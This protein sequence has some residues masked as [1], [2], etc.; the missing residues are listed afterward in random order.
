MEET[1]TEEPKQNNNNKK[2]YGFIVLA[3]V[4]LIGAVTLFFYLR[5]KATHITTDDAFIEGDIH[6]IASKVT[7]TVRN[8][9]V[10]SN[11]FVKRGDILVEL[12]MADYEAKLN[13]TSSIAGA[14]KAKLI[15]VE[16]K[17]KVS[18]SKL[19]ELGAALAAAKA[20]IELQE[21]NLR[22]AENDSRRAE[23]L[24]K[25][26]T[27]SKD[28][29]E[30]TMTAYAVNIAR[31]KAS[32]EQ[33]KQVEKELDTQKDIVK[34]T[35]ASRTIQI[36]TI[37]E[38]EAKKDI[39]QLNYG[40][41]KIYAPVDGYVTKK[42]VELGNQIKD[43]QPLMAIVSLDGI[44]ITANYKETQLEKIKSGQKVKIKVD[45]YSGKTFWG[46][47]DSIMAGTGASFSLF[48]AE[49]AT[50]NYVKVVQRVPVKIV[51]DA[52]TD[53]DHVLRIG[54]SVVPTVII[55]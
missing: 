8:V 33:V 1:K 17:I 37:K 28:R 32:K 40:Y 7:G 30:K 49:N 35:E 54:M 42:S 55:E 36:S 24:F 23:N 47:V 41:T 25:S 6:T 53:K 22:Q 45:S 13:E 10:K 11:Q 43:S 38:K 9:H 3:I 12:D 19:A 20:N 44:H 15:E 50:G 26:G 31:L 29:Y 52:D 5:Y 48:P 46:K 4:V 18:Q 21:A 14:E 27:I 2:K 51:L 34:Q 16:T 39:A